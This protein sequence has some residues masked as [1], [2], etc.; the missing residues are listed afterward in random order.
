MI[1]SVSHIR[2]AFDTKEVLQ[3]ISFHLEAKEK[4]S[5]I[6]INGAGKTTL[7][8]ILLGRLS[9][10]EGEVYL[11]KN[12]SIGYLPQIAE[13]E[14]SNRV[15]EELLTVFDDLRRIEKE[16]HHLEEQME[17]DS[18]TLLLE[19]YADLRHRFEDQNGYQYRSR[20]RGVLAGLGFE[21]SEYS[22]PIEHLSGGQKTRV[23]LG[24]LLLMKP[25]LLLLD[26]P[27]NHLDIESL[28]WLEGFLSSFDGACLI[29]SHDRY[30]LDRLCTKT[31][32]IERGKGTVY[33]GNYT[34]YIQEKQFRQKIAVREYE[35]QQ[36]EIAR[37]EG[38][39]RELRGRGQ[40]KFIKRAQSREKILDKMEVLDKPQVLN[41]SMR[42]HFV[43]NI[44]SGDL[45]LKAEDVAKSFDQRPLFHGLSFEIHK[46]ERVA[47][48]GANGIGKTT[49]FKMILGQE[50][51]TY[52]DLRLGVGV[53]PG[54]YDQT[55]ENLS[56]DKSVLDEIYDTYY[57]ALNV[58]E[59]RNILGCFLFRGDDVF[60]QISNLSGGEKARVSLCKI[61]LSNCNFLLLD[62]PT[63]HLDIASR[64]VLEENLKAY[65]GT[66]LFISHDRYFINQV[67]TRTLELLPDE[68][69]SYLG[70]YDFYLEH[71]RQ[72]RKENEWTE[73]TDSKISFQN[74]KQAASDLRRLKTR[75]N[76]L[77][78]EIEDC[79]AQI[80][81]IKKKMLLP[82]NYSSASKFRQLEEKVSDLEKKIE[83]DML[84]WDEVQQMI[85]EAE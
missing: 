38:I 33:N 71:K 76:R 64:E 35:A 59:I 60:N 51:R 73:I 75:A 7:F 1:V 61:M 79:E 14:S 27:T 25:D 67:A 30:F 23:M 11:Q 20:V 62:E 46:G 81:D 3:D 40:E 48:I 80:E 15:E 45:V 77:E 13:Y 12:L 18:S 52:G 58:P 10:D 34:Y 68:M 78:K 21:E 54:Y 44:E 74:K 8:Q 17:T 65:K 69:V 28:T 26:E 66:I 6:G 42:L 43:P 55:Q 2:K 82:E 41:A 19:R 9:P 85:K 63:N 29:I 5:L 24:K 16:M 50:N 37:Q 22:L 53:F 49:L 31:I 57:P 72:E 70:D 47:L 39:I 36:K 84:L 32:E 83:E 56:P 4:A